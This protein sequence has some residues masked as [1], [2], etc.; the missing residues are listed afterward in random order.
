MVEP[1]TLSSRKVWS[2]VDKPA[3]SSDKALSPGGVKT[4]ARLIDIDAAR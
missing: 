1:F 3:L 2:V 4:K